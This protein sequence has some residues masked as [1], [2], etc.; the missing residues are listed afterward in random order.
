MA[1]H[2]LTVA[3]GFGVRVIPHNTF[4]IGVVAERVLEVES[5]RTLTRVIAA[6]SGP[7]IEAVRG[8]TNADVV[9]GPT[10]KRWMLQTSSVSFPFPSEFRL[11]SPV[12]DMFPFDLVRPDGGLIFMQKAPSTI[13]LM[14]LVTPEQTVTHQDAES[15]DVTY[16]HYGV[17]FR[18]RHVVIRV[19][20]THVLTGQG[21]AEAF[22]D[23]ED[24]IAVMREGARD[25]ASVR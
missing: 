16:D 4:R 22:G 6:E 8:P 15:L 21:R 9:A 3:A 12:D 17:S 1:P 10:C 13:D 18:Q 14:R 11:C 5:E 20:G 23:V 7:R 2:L 19:A 25:T 24:A